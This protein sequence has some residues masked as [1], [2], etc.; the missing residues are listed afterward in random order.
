MV[1]LKAKS[2][3]TGKHRHPAHCFGPQTDWHQILFGAKVHFPKYRK[4][5]S[6]VALEMAFDVIEGDVLSLFGLP[7]STVML[8]NI[9][10]PPLTLGLRMQ[11]FS[12]HLSW[13]AT[14]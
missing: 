8:A 3:A 9:K 13:T 11:A 6:K 4:N 5:S 10:I 2:F 7:S 14:V 12:N 1:S